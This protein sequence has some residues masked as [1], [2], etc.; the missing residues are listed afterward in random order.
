MA[1]VEHNLNVDAKSIA[2]MAQMNGFKFYKEGGSHTLFKHE[3]T[4]E[5]LALP[6]HKGDLK[7]GTAKQLL[8]KIDANKGIESRFQHVKEH[9]DVKV[10]E[11]PSKIILGKNKSKVTIN[12]EKMKEMVMI[13]ITNMIMETV[14]DRIGQAYTQEQWDLCRLQPFTVLNDPKA[15][16]SL[17][18]LAYRVVMNFKSIGESEITEKFVHEMDPKEYK[19]FLKTK[20]DA[21]KWVASNPAGHQNII[22]HYNKSTKAEKE[23]GMNWYSDLH[24][25]AKHIANDTHTDM[26]TMSGLIANYSPQTPWSQNIM[27]AAKVARTKIAV[28][29]PV[30]TFDAEHKPAGVMASHRQLEAAQKMLD[31]DHYD[32]V[33]KGH[34]I[35]A[36]AHLIEFGGND[37]DKFPKVAVDRHAYSVAVGKQANDAQYANAG[38]KGKDRYEEVQGHFIRAAKEISKTTGKTVLPHQLQA[39]TWLT[40]QRLNADEA[41]GVAK[42]TSTTAAT[43]DTR[44]HDYQTKFHPS[45]GRVP[46]TGYNQPHED[47]D[48]PF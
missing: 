41:V 40:R 38:L 11:R 47:D 35:K 1:I 33:M 31:G 18:D 15:P 8:K 24:E 10:P 22:D 26:N 39:I 32:N 21:K 36:F 30:M 6:R 13:K 19:S 37:N 20:K 34:K 27:T 4:G 16:S 2:L 29:G 3:N 12:P 17:K 25:M 5:I 23:H 44:W 43:L 28:G 9:A 14:A 45:I 42:G 46:G 7:P 48:C